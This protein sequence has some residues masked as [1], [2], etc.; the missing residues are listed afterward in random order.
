MAPVRRRGAKRVENREQL[1][2]GDLVLAKIKGFP[3]WPAK[4]SRPEDWKHVP[5]PKKYFVQFFGTLEIAFVAPADVQLFTCELKD[6]LSIRCQGKKDK[7]FARAVKEICEEF[8]QLQQKN[9]TVVRND[10][11]KETL[12]SEEQQLNSAAEHDGG[13]G[14]EM[15]GSKDN[16]E[17]E[18]SNGPA[19]E[20]EHCFQRQ[21]EVNFEEVKPCLSDEV[22]PDAV[23]TASSGK[24]SKLL[25][26]HARNSASLPDPCLKE[27]C[28]DD[29]KVE[30]ASCD[31][32]LKELTS[33][34]K[35]KATGLK[36][37]PKDAM[38]SNSGS[39][40]HCHQGKHSLG[41]TTMVLSADISRSDIDVGGEK[42]GKVDLET[43]TDGGDNSEG[44]LEEH[45]ESTSSKQMNAKHGQEKQKSQT[46]ESSFPGKLSKCADTVK[47]KVKANESRK[48]N[49]KS[50]NVLDEKMTSTKSKKL[51]SAG[52]STN[53]Y[54]IRGRATIN[55]SNHSS[56]EDD[57]PPSKRHCRS[58]AETSSTS[59]ADNR[60][61]S[62]VSQ[63]IDS[64]LRKSARSPV[65]QLPAKRR[66]V[67]LCDDEDDESLKTPI[68]GRLANKVSVVPCAADSPEKVIM[69]VENNVENQN[70]S[71]NPGVSD[72]FLKEQGKLDCESNKSLS[73][74]VGQGVGQ[75]TRE[76]S[77]A[78]VCRSPQKLESEELPSLEAIS[79]FISP[80]G[81]SQSVSDTRLYGEE[82]KRSCEVP[83][84]V[85]LKKNSARDSIGATAFNRSVTL[86]NQSVDKRI[87]SA[88][89][90][91]WKTTPKTDLLIKSPGLGTKSESTT[92]LEERLDD[93]KVDETS[94]RSDSKGSG[95]PLS[96]KRLIAAAQARKRQA[97]SQSTLENS[98]VHLF[99][100][101][102]MPRTVP[103]P[104]LSEPGFESSKMLQLDMQRLFS[105]SPLPY[106]HQLSSS[107]QQENEDR[108]KRRVNSDHQGTGSPVSGSIEAA[109]ARD[110]FEG[111]IETLSRTKESI[112][113]ATRLAI[114]CA[115]RGIANEVLDLLIKK[116]E[117]E[118]S[119]HRRVDLFFLVDSITQCSSGQRGIVG[120]S[121]IPIVQAALPRLI[122]AAAPA[123]T[124]AL[125][126]RRQCH[127][128]LRLWLERK[129]LPESILRRYMDDLGVV[130][131]NPSAGFSSRRPLRNERAFD[132]PIR[133]MEGMVVD[134]YGS[135]ATFKL[136][137]LLSAHS[138]QE[139][140]VYEND[141]PCKV[142]DDASP[143]K[144]SPVRSTHLEN[145]TVT[146]NDQ[147]HCI[148]KHVDGE[149]EME[150]LSGHPMDERSL[151]SNS[152]FELALHEPKS[153]IALDSS[154]ISAGWLSSP[155]GS[156]PL[157]P[158]SCP[159]TPP[160]PSSPPPP[161][162]SLQPLPPPPSFPLGQPS[163]Q[164]QSFSQ[165]PACPPKLVHPPLAAGLPPPPPPRVG[166]PPPPPAGLPAPP[167][168]GLPPPPRVGLASPPV[169]QPVVAT[170]LPSAG[171]PSLLTQQS[172]QFQP[173][174]MSQH[175]APL[176]SAVSHS[177]Q[178]AYQRRPLLHD[179][180][181]TP[182]GNQ[183]T[184][185]F[186]NAHGS[187]FDGIVRTDVQ[188]KQAPCVPP[189]RVNAPQDYVS[190]NSSRHGE[191]GQSGA[192]MNP[193]APQHQ[194]QLLPAGA[195]LAQRP[196]LSELP[197]QGP[198]SHFSYK[199]SIQRHQ[200]SLCSTPNSS[201]DSG[202][203]GMGKCW[204]TQANEL[205]AD[206]PCSGWVQQGRSCL[207]QPYPYEGY[208]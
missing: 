169:A 146:P 92:S 89:V 56:D 21:N 44:N 66:A 199:N 111:M 22:D 41:C 194:Q 143:T 91:K 174:V 121:Y 15:E 110:A 97:H 126:N 24:N 4:I 75:K 138:F 94:F 130:N 104:I 140:E 112:G 181:G 171:P 141:D 54:P 9:A 163:L 120:A 26:D 200:Y 62:S 108:E 107:N 87:K 53:R 14:T 188:S 33:G 2:L 10:G 71:R 103:N 32:S 95:S 117:N 134:E 115:K 198:P 20:L 17:M 152:S 27:P 18:G 61:K 166:L 86:I 173:P 197:P 180:G 118:S 48:I 82:N 157:P 149:L 39:S 170:H 204:R 42:K 8:Q 165:P 124:T 45:K 63:K 128:V 55:E 6:K 35:K 185:V 99:P 13:N 96:M 98:F 78:N 184:H 179:A 153:D 167:P 46:K 196:V 191:Y 25:A 203:Y 148:L 182:S 84:N 176:P 85:S 123:D 58:L 47:D 136:H 183:H 36:K 81:S 79:V 109:G 132:D 206:Y 193:H 119:L 11:S 189:P 116:L 192:Y 38:C 178:S 31:F 201:E 64:V 23:P 72:D 144:H 186:S 68:H 122:R 158:G 19:S 150:D 30:D 102:D 29:F 125:E 145:Y 208:R 90:E 60:L 168:A 207:G 159:V 49:A 147:R 50:P 100:E 3:A 129:I 133:E 69:H 160:L 88:S 5:D 93:D 137:E 34:N 1:N 28:S 156:P 51:T 164:Q 142:D 43:E 83:K 37:K 65:K 190:Y 187:H 80:K 151:L 16:L 202:R 127:K 105:T 74:A 175:M 106:L 52:K 57:L 135:N 177:P 7:Y 131:E 139:D 73:P 172:V 70:I 114:D 161:S 12:A 77:C 205:N 154:N 67:R 40:G 162:P 59:V 101:I 113:R 195:H 155:E 76:I